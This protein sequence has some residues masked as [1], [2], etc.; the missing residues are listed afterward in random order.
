M[1]LTKNC[2]VV[3][4]FLIDLYKTGT[5]KDQFFNADNKPKKV[6]F[7]EFEIIMDDLKLYDYIDFDSVGY[8]KT[9]INSN[10]IN[11]CNVK[12]HTKALKYKEISWLS[13]KEFI[14]KSIVIPIGVSIITSVIVT[15]IN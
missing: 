14:F 1:T 10:R 9:N 7:D 8:D 12:L 3:L 11:I 6:S 15:L 2:K 4:N 5:L 13:L